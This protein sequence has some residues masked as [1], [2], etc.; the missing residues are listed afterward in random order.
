MPHTRNDRIASDEPTIAAVMEALG[1]I[2]DPE[3][4]MDIVN[5]GLIRA[6]KIDEN[7]L[8]V[9]MTLTSPA[10]PVGPWFQTE[11]AEVLESTFPGWHPVRVDL[12][13]YP[14]WSAD[15]MSPLARRQLGYFDG[16]LPAPRHA[17]P[18]AGTKRT[19]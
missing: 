14:P 17:G 6:I 18:T 4:G 15:D 16:D 9:T 5:L 8:H 12:N 19:S 3:L 10:C 1:T 11:V 13:S 7:G 2:D